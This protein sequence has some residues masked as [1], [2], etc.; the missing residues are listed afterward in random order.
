MYNFAETVP[1]GVA[2]SATMNPRGVPPF[3]GIPVEAGVEGI[4]NSPVLP[5]INLGWKGKVGHS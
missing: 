4:K 2:P 3:D 1:I 5:S